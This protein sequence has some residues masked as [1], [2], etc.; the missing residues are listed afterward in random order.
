MYAVVHG[1]IDPGLRQKSAQILGNLPFDGFAIGGSVGKNKAEMA[2]M[3]RHVVPFLPSDKPNHLLG[4]GDLDSVAL[5]IP[6]GIDT[7]DSSYPTRAARHGM[8]LTQQ[9]P[10]NLTKKENAL[11]FE[12]IEKNCRCQTC[13]HYTRAYLHHLFKAREVTALTL[14]TIHN[15]T[16][17]VDLM[18]RYRNQ[19]LADEI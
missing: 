5:S 19:I 17:M 7:F 3:L 8:A 10:L 14:A 6:L 16:Y 18:Q 2:A 12:P 11:S 1:G 4:I 15:L 9:G 13:A